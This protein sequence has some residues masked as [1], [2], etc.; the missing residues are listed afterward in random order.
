MTSQR[1]LIG[2]GIAIPVLVVLFIVAVIVLPSLFTKP[3]VNF[4]YAAGISQYGYGANEIPY[5]DLPTSFGATTRTR[6]YYVVRKEHLTREV[7]QVSIDQ[8]RFA[9]PVSD[10]TEVRFYLHDVR[11]NSSREISFEQAAAL[12]LNDSKES[13]DGFR[14]QY[15]HNRGG[16]GIIFPFVF[17]DGGGGEADWELTGRGVR[18]SMNL[19]DPVANRYER[20]ILFLGW[21]VD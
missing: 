15:S 12:R 8:Q 19:Q 7:Q 16:G 21:I 11:L 6:E 2:I 17:F 1:V 4:V 18:H 14:L 10:L 3:T 20:S 5:R 9:R 13:P